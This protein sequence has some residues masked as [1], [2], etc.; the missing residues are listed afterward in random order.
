MKTSSIVLTLVLLAGVVVSCK[1]QNSNIPLKLTFRGNTM[2]SFSVVPAAGEKAYQ[3]IIVKESVLPNMPLSL[4]IPTSILPSDFLLRVE[5]RNPQN[6]QPQVEE[7]LFFVENAPVEISVNPVAMPNPDSTQFSPNDQNNITYQAFQQEVNHSREMINL[8]QN[9]LMRYDKKDQKFYVQTLKEYRE[10]LD[11]HNKFVAQQY[12]KHKHLFSASTFPL[13][14]LTPF[15][16]TKDETS[17]K[18]LW[19]KNY[20]TSY[21]FNDSRVIRTSDFRRWL[22]TYVN[23]HF[24]KNLTR[25]QTESM[26]AQ[27]GSLAI[28]AAQKG[29]PEICGWVIDYFYN[30][31]ESMGYTQGIVMLGKYINNEKCTATKKWN[32]QYRIE[33][34]NKIFVGATAPN[35]TFTNINNQTKTLHNFGNDKPYKI[36]I[37]WSADCSHCMEFV[38]QFYPF[39]ERANLQ[40]WFNVLAVSLDETETEIP[41]WKK[42]TEQ[43]PQW[44]HTRLQQGL[45]SPEAREYYV[46][47]TP[48]IFIIETQ[49]GKIAAIPLSAK[50]IFEFWQKNQ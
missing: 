12:Q 9:L 20:I 4:A 50:E 45:S 5:F 48:T 34:L 1:T 14:T 29:V 36:L 47:S 35:F 24:D 17:A 25:S 13:Y 38:N 26:L 37:F 18:N 7:I 49:S 19:L 15:D 10:R 33:S 32:I 28:E 21:P 44:E 11:E 31:Y 22:D 2:V 43:L 30:G 6:G 3:P 40:Q 8:L 39:Y 46:L 23:H 41:V 42:A 27:A 16:F